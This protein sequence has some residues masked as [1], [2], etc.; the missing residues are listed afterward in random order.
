MWRKPVKRV[1]CKKQAFMSITGVDFE[2][3]PLQCF[4]E[5]DRVGDEMCV[6]HKLLVS[7][8]QDDAFAYSTTRI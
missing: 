4:K 2:V 8:Q 1:Y 3:S 6:L 5:L 7:S